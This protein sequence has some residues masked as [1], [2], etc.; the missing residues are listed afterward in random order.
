[1]SSPRLTRRDSSRIGL[2]IGA[3]ATSHRAL[4][5]G[6]EPPSPEPSIPEAGPYHLDGTISREVLE[7]D[8]SRSISMEGLLNGRGD[9]DDNIRMPGSRT[10]RSPRDRM[11][12]YYADRPSPAVPEGF[13]QEEAIRAIW[14]A[15]SPRI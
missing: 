11:R 13:N 15:D 12:W 5:R 10:L 8:L 9:L 2:R 6:D 7:N 4:A 14:A 3:W 1:M